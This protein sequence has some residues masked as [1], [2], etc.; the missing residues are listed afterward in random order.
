MI[1]KL[2][3]DGIIKKNRSGFWGLTKDGTKKLEKLKFLMVSAFDEV[4]SRKEKH[5]CDIRTSAYI[6]AVERVAQAM[7]DRGL[8]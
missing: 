4:W 8:A 1:S 2:K 6:L 5:K 3:A 7:R